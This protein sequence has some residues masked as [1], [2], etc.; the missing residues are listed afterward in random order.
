MDIASA[1]LSNQLLGSTKKGS[2][3]EVVAWLGAVQAQ[4]FAAAKW[5]LGLRLHRATDDAVEKAFDDG[6]ILRVHVMRPTWHFLTPQDLRCVQAL[7]RSRAQAGMAAGYRRLELDGR[8]LSRCHRV[9]SDALA[10]GR[11]LTRSELSVRLAEKRV[12]ASGQRLAYILMHAEFE[13]LIC[14]GPRKGRQFTYALVEE[15]VPRTAALSAEEALAQ[16]TLR[17]F[18]S[19][20]PAQAKDFA[21]WSGMTLRE[22]QRG[23]QMAAEQLQ[24]ESVNGETYWFS[25]ATLEDPAAG[26]EALLLSL[27]DEYTIGYRDRSAQD[28]ERR[29]E[30]LISKGNSVNAVLVLDGRIAGTWKR[31]LAKGRVE[32]LARPFRKLRKAEAEAFER[33][34][35]RYAAF[36]QL[37]VSLR[38]T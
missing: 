16:W 35:S 21:W 11:H 24:R 3:A 30:R 5:G 14:S 15:R 2:P 18:L 23:L 10:G 22:A 4:D 7:T 37:P 29:I 9:L 28:A 6:V 34:A 17:Y 8:L 38:L 13:A 32:I 20:G 27:Y 36:L 19:H 31:V 26:P 25:P 33:A 12:H 1:R